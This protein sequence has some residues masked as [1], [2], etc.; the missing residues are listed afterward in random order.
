MPTIEEN[1]LVWDGSYSWP[2]G[3]DEWSRNWGAVAM[4]WYGTILPRIYSFLTGGTILEIGCGYGRWT[5]YLKDHCERLLAVDL[6]QQCIAACRR[7]F[8]GV[9]HVSFHNND[10]VSLR[11]IE[12][13]AVDFVFSFD[14]LPLVDDTTMAAYIAQL[15]RVLKREGVAFLHHSNLGAYRV[16]N[17]LIRRNPRIEMLLQRL[18]FPERDLH[19][20]DPCVSSK[21]VC[22][23]AAA[24]G[25]RCVSQETLRWGT[26]LLSV[27][28]LSVL[29]HQGSSRDRECRRFHNWRFDDEV[30]N[31]ARLARLYGGGRVS[32]P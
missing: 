10:G 31:L 11:M 8:A 3:G 28:C 16:W 19:W 14:A 1:R 20:R 2:E 29:V 9:P 25:L 6:S 22:C 17:V 4:Q 27:E 18:G 21:A 26:R 13:D 15:P 23:W 5:H 7:R 24:H 30:A 32:N 12:A